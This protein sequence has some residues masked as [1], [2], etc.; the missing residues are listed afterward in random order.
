MRRK[1]VLVMNTL[2]K[3]SVACVGV[4]LLAVAV[5]TTAF[6]AVCASNVSKLIKQAPYQALSNTLHPNVAA[7]E[8]AVNAVLTAAN[9]AAKETAYNAMVT[10]IETVLFPGIGSSPR[11]L[12]TE[13][14][15][16]V[17]YDS[18]QIGKTVTNSNASC[19]TTGSV[20][21]N[22]YPSFCTKQVNENHNSRVAILDAQLFPCG[23]GL[24]TKF[25][26]SVNKF[27]SGVAERM[28]DYLNNDGTARYSIDQ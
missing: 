26:T 10:Q 9:P 24:E 18:A 21:R 8:A 7:L 16:T 25:S 1:G 23:L 20:S 28:G 14:D 27:Q 12:L 15:G 6:A 5:N 13:S 2:L 19:G 3:K 22:S 17:I 4:A 11:L